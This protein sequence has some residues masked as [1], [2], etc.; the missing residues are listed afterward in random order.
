MQDGIG[1]RG[2]SFGAYLAGGW[3]EKGEKFG[4]APSLI[5][6]WLSGGMAFR[7]PASPRLRDGLIGPGFIFIQL[8]DPSGLGLLVRQLDYSFFSGV[9][10]SYTVTVPLLRLRRA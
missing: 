1:R 5:L 2:Y 3:T 6:M 9:S 7:L 10:G 4:G 8:Y